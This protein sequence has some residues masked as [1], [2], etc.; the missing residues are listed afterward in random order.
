MAIKQAQYN[1]TK[2]SGEDIYHFETDDKMV[3]I[4]DESGR[5]VGT[6]EELGFS[7]KV[8]NNG[9]FKDLKHTGL[10]A[11]KGMT[12]LPAGILASDTSILS[13]VNAKNSA[14]II[15]YELLGKNGEVYHNTISQGVEKGWVDGGGTN[16]KNIINQVKNSIGNLSELQ[17]TRKTSI[18]GAINALKASTDEALGKVGDAEQSLEE[19]QDHN[20]DS[21]YIKKTGDKITGDL[22]IGNGSAVGGELTT[23]GRVNIAKVS[24]NAVEV[25][26]KSLVL[27]IQGKEALKYNGRKV[28]TET[29][30]GDGSG[31]DADKIDGIDGVDLAVLSKDNTYTKTQ[32]FNSTV[33]LN[34]TSL[35]FNRIMYKTKDGEETTAVKFEDVGRIRFQLK[36]SKQ[37]VIIEP[38]GKIVTFSD[39]TISSEEQFAGMRFRRWSSQKG[40]GFELDRNSSKLVLH[41][42]DSNKTGFKFNSDGTIEFASAPSISG[43][44][45]FIQAGTPTGVKG[46]VWIKV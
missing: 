22:V 38:D 32:R 15:F 2:T 44:K 45:L 24:N 10:Y 14:T 16:L 6:L 26:D 19:L 39:I 27:D 3:M 36:D 28:W 7:G 20:H 42:W 17:T 29:H 40:K 13:V 33:V 8:I 11:V 4:I 31:L 35:G 12:G 46:D 18:V 43:N 37:D 30:M 21:R 5:T 1:I 34:G 23:G 41:D 25:G 9:S